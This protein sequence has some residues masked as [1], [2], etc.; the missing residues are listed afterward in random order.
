MFT[1]EQTETKF[2]KMF[3]SQNFVNRTLY[4]KMAAKTKRFA[5]ERSSKP[6]GK[7]SVKRK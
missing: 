6:L 4:E 2:Q 3:F 7:T 5:V 1:T